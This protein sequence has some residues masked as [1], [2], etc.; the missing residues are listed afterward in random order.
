MA[1]FYFRGFVIIMQDSISFNGLLYGINRH[2]VTN[3][4]MCCHHGDAKFVKLLNSLSKEPVE[5]FFEK[6]SFSFYEDEGVTF[7]KIKT[8]EIPHFNFFERLFYD[9]S[10]LQKKL[11]KKREQDVFTDLVFHMSE[12]DFRYLRENY[13]YISLKQLDC[14]KEFLLKH[15]KPAEK[16]LAESFFSN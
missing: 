10:T 11:L 13:L 5:K 12:F 14:F 16:E 2:H 9:I 1:K 4:V 6:N 8:K 15:A 3:P 7:V